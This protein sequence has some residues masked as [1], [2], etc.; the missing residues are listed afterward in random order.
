MHTM[1][2]KYAVPDLDPCVLSHVLWLSKTL[3]TISVPNF[4]LRFIWVCPLEHFSPLN[5]FWQQKFCL[6]GKKL[7]FLAN[8][9]ISYILQIERRIVSTETSAWCPKFATD[10]NVRF[11]TISC[12]FFANCMNI[13]HKTEVQ[14]V[15]LR[16]WTGLKPNWFKSYGTNE[17]K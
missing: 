17:K 1:R 9:W 3:C 6:S 5:S 7:K 16:C 12:R 13:F 15:I 4:L 2:Y 14:T 10:L 11:R 8:I